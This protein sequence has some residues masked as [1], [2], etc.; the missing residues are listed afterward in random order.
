MSAKEIFPEV[1]FLPGNHRYKSPLWKESPLLGEFRSPGNSGRESFEGALKVLSA[2]DEEIP[3]PKERGP[4]VFRD[5]I[6]QIDMEQA[7][8]PKSID[9]NLKKLIDSLMLEDR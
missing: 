9:P 3:V 8:E 4:I 7:G 1:A 5:G 6:F 2:E